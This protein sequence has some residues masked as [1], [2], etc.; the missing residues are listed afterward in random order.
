MAP[1]RV[2]LVDL[3]TMLSDVIKEI[4][5][6]DPSIEVV[7]EIPGGGA[8]VTAIAKNEADVVIYGTE[9]RELT[10]P[11][12]QLFKGNL[13]VKVVAL[14]DDGQEA[15]L[16]ELCPRREELGE[17]SPEGLIAAVRRGGTSLD[18]AS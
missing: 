16:Y 6:T 11:W 14:V 12:R 2:L 5:A 9:D 7:G 4:L 13:D 18:D 17:L 3:T 15:F 10:A 8:V 1:I